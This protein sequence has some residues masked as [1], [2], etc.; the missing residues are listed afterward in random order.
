MVDGGMS[1][2][3]R[4]EM[5]GDANWTNTWT[6][7]AMRDAKRLV[8][9]QMANVGAVIAGPAETDLCIHVC[10]IHVNLSAMCVHNVADLADGCFKNAV[11]AWIG[12]HQCCQIA[13]MS[14]GLGA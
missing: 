1:W 5:F 3:K 4:L 11:R 6:A 7:A 9:I 12:H 14:V 10:A 8:Q 2:Q 13:R